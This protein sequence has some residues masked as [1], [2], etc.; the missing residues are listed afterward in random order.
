VEQVETLFIRTLDDLERRVSTPD[1]YELL[2]ASALIRKLLLDDH[3]LTDQV[4]REFQ[5]KV[6]FTV[7]E[8]IPLPLGGPQPVI[9]T[10]Q[11][12]LDPSTAP[13]WLPR[14][15]LNRDQFMAYPLAKVASH[16][17]TV[18]EVVLFEANVMGGV[19]AGSP[20]S[21]KREALHRIETTFYVGG[22][23]SSLRQLQAI[24]RVVLVALAPLRA[25]IMAKHGA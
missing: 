24:G 21:E 2:G 5:L 18:R 4:N 25:A 20:G 9:E 14:K 1:A 7:A 17:Y 23:P 3:P 8:P 19:H 16:T 15:T 13:P 11:D 22:L 6:R 12:G 10:I